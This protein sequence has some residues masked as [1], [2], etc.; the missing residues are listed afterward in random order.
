[1]KGRFAYTCHLYY[2]DGIHPQRRIGTFPDHQKNTYHLKSLST[3]LNKKLRWTS[4]STGGTVLWI[5]RRERN[6]SNWWSE[7]EAQHNVFS[8]DKDEKDIGV[9]YWN[10]TNT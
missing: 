9:P 2:H 1:M 7:S 4:Y 3:C 10:M 5:L 8:T 6:P